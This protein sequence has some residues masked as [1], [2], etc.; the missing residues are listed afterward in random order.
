MTGISLIKGIPRIPHFK[1]AQKKRTMRTQRPP[2]AAPTRRGQR[3]RL[4]LSYSYFFSIPS[5]A[6]HAPFPYTDTPLSP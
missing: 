4:F 6:F 2:G 1:S 3:I 5:H